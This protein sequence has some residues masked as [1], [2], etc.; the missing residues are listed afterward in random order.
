MIKEE[1]QMLRAT[2]TKFIEYQPTPD[3]SFQEETIKSPVI[4]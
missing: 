2:K 4:K 3:S 1:I